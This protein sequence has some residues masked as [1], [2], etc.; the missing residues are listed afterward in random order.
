MKLYT[1]TDVK[2]LIQLYRENEETA[3][4]FFEV[5]MSVL[6]TLNFQ[7]FFD[8]LLS[9]IMQKFGVGSVWVTLI[10]RSRAVKLIH[11]YA[12][13]AIPAK[14][15]RILERRK[16]AS[17][18]KDTGR[19]VLGNQDMDRFSPLMPR[20]REK[21]YGSI[22]VVP[23]SLDGDPV[24]SINFA[25]ASPERFSPEVDT[26]LLEQLGLVVS[27]CLSNVAAHEELKALA[28]K[29]PLT[30]LLNRRAMERAL[31]RE[32]GRSKRYRSPL[33]VAFIDLDDFKKVNDTL[34]HDSGDGILV[35]VADTL[36][37]MSRSSD[38]ISRFAGDEFVIILPE[39]AAAEA[40]ALI[41]RIQEH[42]REH[43][44]SLG[45]IQVPVGFSCGVASP[46]HRPGEDASSLLKKA[47]KLLYQD[48][49]ARKA[50]R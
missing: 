10:D 45:G 2:R 5:E 28:F 43:P 1:D 33:S 8:K 11:T 25:D 26:I 21:R 38:V 47:D 16:F 17:V 50:G 35:H 30:G 42:F 9:N 7:D 20:G 41:G 44:V 18:V 37:K 27:I 39:T 32:I 13:A 49:Q 46:E 34:G 48:K 40:N 12:S 14:N 24:G 3:L 29:D 22:A 6:A 23:I 15:L 4:K 19:P 31:K 36:R